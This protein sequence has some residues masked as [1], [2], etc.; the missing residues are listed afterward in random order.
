MKSTVLD[1]DRAGA[2]HVPT[3]YPPGP[4]K[5][6]LGVPEDTQHREEAH[7]V[8]ATVVRVKPLLVVPRYEGALAPLRVLHSGRHLAGEVNHGVFLTIGGNYKVQLF[9]YAKQKG[10]IVARHKN[11]VG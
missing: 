11:P 2:A 4:E 10:A 6:G 7:R 9:G 5:H 3:V 8:E 1:E